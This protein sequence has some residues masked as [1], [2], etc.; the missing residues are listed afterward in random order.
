VKKISGKGKNSFASGNDTLGPQQPPP[1]Y[2]R[3]NKPGL[4]S[5]NFINILLEPF[6]YESVMF[7]FF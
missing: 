7:S 5:V 1:L 2:A 6:L 4:P 3:A